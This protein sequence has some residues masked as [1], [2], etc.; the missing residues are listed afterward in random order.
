[1]KNLRT[2]LLTVTIVLVIGCK[3]K[4]VLPSNTEEGLNTFGVKIDGKIWLAVTKFN[5]TGGGEKIR[6]G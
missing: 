6:G 3:D 2:A 4:E 1:M 5:I